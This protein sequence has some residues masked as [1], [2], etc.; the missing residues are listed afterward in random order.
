MTPAKPS[1]DLLRSLTD[2]HVLRAFMT[3]GRLTRAEL[4]TRTGISKPTVSESVRRLT[5]AGLLRDTGERTSGRGRIGSYYALAGDVGSALVVSA[6]PEGIVAEVVDA[7]GEVLARAV[8]QV[9]R[10]ARPAAVAGAIKTTARRVR[11][12]TSAPIRLAV[13]SAADPVD[14]TTGRLVHL[15]DAPFL[16]G[17][18]APTEALAGI[19]DGPVLVDNDVNWAARAERAASPTPLDDFAYVHL[20]EGLGCAVVSDG[21]VRR[22]HTGLAG[23]I[24]HLVTA[25]PGGQALTFTEVFRGLGLR[26]AGSTAVDVDVLLL[27]VDSAEGEPSADVLAVLATAICGV[28]T[29]IVTLCDPEVILIGGEWGRRPG[30]LGAVAA[31]FEQLPRH[32]PVRPTLIVDEPA[33]AGARSHALAELRS[34]IV[35]RTRD[36]PDA[37]G[38]HAGVGNEGVGDEG[39][40]DAVSR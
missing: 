24:A 10:P 3:E 29:A 19:V 34:A 30:V 35:G 18:L 15:P 9:R 4:A 25:G 11:D 6:A 27:A 28:L 5:A 31:R 14:R 40:R 12:S 39:V 33:L 22:G 20:G 36:V 13:V 23:E 2:E 26:R 32:V 17:D 7:R 8:E 21:E 1:L 38:R 16:I 37:G